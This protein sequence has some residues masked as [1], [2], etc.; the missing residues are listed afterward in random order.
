MNNGP[1]PRRDSP[2][3]ASVEE[4]DAALL[5]N[6]DFKLLWAAESVSKLGSQVTFLALPLTAVTLLDAS[7]LE[8]SILTACETAAY[9]IVGLPAGGWVDRLRRRPILMW[10]NIGRSALLASITIAWRFGQLSL[11]QLYV[12]ALSSGVLS[13][14]FEVAY[15]SYLPSL[16]RREQL[17]DGNAKLQAGYSVAVIIGP[18]IGG[19]L[20]QLFGAAGALAFD[21]LT[22]VASSLGLKAIRRRE[23]QPE[24]KPDRRLMAEVKEGLQFVL[25]HRLLWAIAGSTA[26][27]NLASNMTF[28]LLVVYMTRDLGLTPSGIGVVFGFGA[29]GGLLGALCASALGRRVGAARAII[30]SSAGAGLAGLVLPLAGPGRLVVLIAVSQFATSFFVVCYNAMQVGFRQAITPPELLGRMNATIRFVVWGTFPIGAL[31]GGSVASVIGVRSALWI[32]AALA[33]GAV[34]WLILSPLRVLKDLPKEDTGPR[35]RAS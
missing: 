23:R 29:T 27:F 16:I 26:T 22:Y 30:L 13:V 35:L 33:V 21:A 9:L 6:R 2:T 5:R 3:T 10:T 15:Q 31:L 19:L 34:G 4:P 25:S 1:D 8:V 12:V 17:V 28:A 11:P 7:A 24:R 18:S 32:A 20:V 14:F